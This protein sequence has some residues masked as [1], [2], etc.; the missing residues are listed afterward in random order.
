MFISTSGGTGVTSQRGACKLQG[1]SPLFICKSL[2]YSKCLYMCIIPAPPIPCFMLQWGH[3]NGLSPLHLHN[4]S[5]QLGR[6]SFKW[7]SGLEGWSQGSLPRNDLSTFYCWQAF[8]TFWHNSIFPALVPV[9]LWVQVPSWFRLFSFVIMM[10]HLSHFLLQIQL[11]QA[12]NSKW[13]IIYAL[14]Q[15]SNNY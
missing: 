7:V 6:W 15:A 14:P 13:Y 2:I 1:S 5:L 12:Y 10:V 9:S 4:S 3:Y 8:V 11:R